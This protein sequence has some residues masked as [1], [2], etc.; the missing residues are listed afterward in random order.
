MCAS[1]WLFV[2][3]ALLRLTTFAQTAEEPSSCPAGGGGGPG[4]PASVLETVEKDPPCIKWRQTGG[5]SPRGKREKHGDKGCAEEIATGS[6]GYCQCGHG[7]DKKIVRESN[8]DH[9]PFKCSTECLQWRRY[10]CL[11]WRQTGGCSADGE[12]EEQQDKPCDALINSRMSGFCE[13]GDG[14]VIKKPGCDHGEHEESFKCVDE[15]LREPDLYEELGLESSATADM[16]KK[17][18]R[19]LS[20]KYHPDKTR[21]DPKMTARFAAIR[22][23]YDLLD[24]EG[25]RGIYDVAGFQMVDL[26]KNNKAEKG[27]AM[28][29]E[30][31]VT[32]DQLYNG[33]EFQ[34]NIQSKVICR[35]CESAITERCV[36]CTSGCANERE[37]RNVQMGPMV[38][39]QQVEVPSKQKCRMQTVKLSVGIDR[40]M[41]EGETLTFKCKGEQRP[42]MVPGD[43]VLKLKE[44]KH[45]VFRRVGN[46]L[47]T[48]IDV[49]LIEALVGFE[50]TIVHLDGRK[51][52]VNYD[53]VTK[54][55]GIIQ[56][57]GE[58]MPSRGDPTTR[59]SLLIKCRFLMP[60][61]GRQWLQEHAK[62]KGGS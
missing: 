1:R 40:G 5:C 30:V 58:G 60:E 18:F 16:I 27:P 52:V 8:C 17:V 31:S 42:K 54:P 51:I 48:E 7:D 3:I 44:I 13:C 56:I 47:H 12:R 10:T 24:D 33:A 36:K 25:Q 38:M 57:E 53:K 59:G 19:K 32:L 22:E 35:G 9:R 45:K 6:S 2:S 46:D 14:R 43:V 34:T 55:N 26:A 23:A 61:D 62:A 11:G 20:L 37:L 28:N 29:A 39:Q 49:T 15:C 21:N 4:C 50:R 41:S